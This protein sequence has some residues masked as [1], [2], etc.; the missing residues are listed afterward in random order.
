MKVKRLSHVAIMVK[1]L[2]KAG[3]LFKEL[4]DFKFE[5]PAEIKAT[6]TRTLY[7]P[8]S[9]VEL[10]APLTTDGGVA[11]ALEKRGEGLT[12]MAL[13]VE[14]LEEAIKHMQ[15]HNIR[16][17]GRADLPVGK[18]ATFHPKDLYGVM[19]ELIERPKK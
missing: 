3:K 16:M 4:F 19:I 1:D 6:D 13:D 2:D 15:A 12:M 17:L 8:A 10:V 18:T 7:A 14:N 9:N 5:P 11:R